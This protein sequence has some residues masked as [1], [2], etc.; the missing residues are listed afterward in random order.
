MYQLSLWSK[1]IGKMSD[2]HRKI[3]FSDLDGTLLNDRKEIED[4]TKAALEE[5]LQRG[6]YFAICT[7]RPLASAKNVARQYHLDKKGC[8]IVAYNGGAIY[9]P[10]EQKVI[11][12]ASVPL[13]LAK[14]L[15]EKAEEAGLY[16]QAYDHADTVL[17]RRKTPELEFYTNSTKSAW[18]TGI[19]V[20]D[21]KEE[22]SKVLVINLDS[23]EKLVQFH[24]ANAD[25]TKDRMNSFFSRV[26]LLEYCPLGVSKGA[27]MRTLCEHLGISMKDSV[28]AGDERNDIPMLEAA[29]I[30]AVPANAHENACAA[31][32]Y[33][34]RADNN[35]GAVGEI[36]RKFIFL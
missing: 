18:K 3:L 22:P 24:E 27:G 14:K 19:E 10:I 9:D 17:T 28:A 34:C 2:H 21:L 31:A 32:D 16:V 4:G 1:E 33:I 13:A 26:E 12:Y 6:H 5:M 29:G 8:Y 30:A 23:H 11:S 36:I 20:S 7:G 15:Y 35:Q 25:W